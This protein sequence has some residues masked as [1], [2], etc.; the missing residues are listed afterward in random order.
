MTGDHDGQDL[1]RRSGPVTGRQTGPGAQE[2]VPSAP[3]RAPEARRLAVVLSRLSGCAALI[4]GVPAWDR[5]EPGGS[6]AFLLFQAGA[7]AYAAAIFLAQPGQELASVPAGDRPGS[8]TEAMAAAASDLEAFLKA[9]SKPGGQPISAAERAVI[10]AA[11]AEAMDTVG[12]YVLR[13]A[14]P[15]AGE[16]PRDQLRRAARLVHAAACQVRRAG[17]G[18]R[19]PAMPAAGHGERPDARG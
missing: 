14:G 10:I 15:V 2:Q 8:P 4:T 11:L 13:F 16:K 5:R 18:R 19:G 9:A 17:A 12:G 7:Q 3:G 1:A 6:P